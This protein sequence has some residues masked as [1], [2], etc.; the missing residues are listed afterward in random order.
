MIHMV[1]DDPMRIS[2]ARL[3]K[4]DGAEM[5]MERSSRLEPSLEFHAEPEP[6]SPGSYTVGWRGLAS[7]G[8]ALQGSFC[9]DLTDRDRVLFAL[10]QAD[11]INWLSITVK[12]LAYAATLSTGGSVLILAV[13]RELSERGR[14]AL[15]LTAALTTVSAPPGNGESEQASNKTAPHGR[16]HQTL[17]VY[18]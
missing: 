11:A 1:F 18:S 3:V 15:R 13:L 10:S 8:H 16:A 17:G 6:L 9:F 2:Y 5:P 14:A 12:V 7:D 4:A